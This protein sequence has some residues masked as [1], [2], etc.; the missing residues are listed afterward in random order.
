MELDTESESESRDGSVRSR[1][2]QFASSA[3]ESAAG[4]SDRIRQ[5]AGIHAAVAMMAL[6][7]LS[8]SVAAQS[9]EHCGAGIGALVYDMQEIVLYVALGVIILGAAAGMALRMFTPF[10]CAT[11]VG[12]VMLLAAIGGPIA[13]VV[14]IT[15]IEMIFATVGIG[16][17]QACSPFL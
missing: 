5:Q 6:V 11:S 7:S 3:K 16:A 12:G 1:V 13:F 10:P 17:S 15:F 4:Q 2:E 8:T 9:G 14:V